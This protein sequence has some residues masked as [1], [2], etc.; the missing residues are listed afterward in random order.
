[1]SDSEN[2]QFGAMAQVI[3]ANELDG[4]LRT[5]DWARFAAG[6]NG[7]NYR[8]NNYDTRL[9]AAV[10]QIRREALPDLRARGTMT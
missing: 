6:H 8:M 1:M 3:K 4:A 9:A 5:H 10:A 7:P 2:A